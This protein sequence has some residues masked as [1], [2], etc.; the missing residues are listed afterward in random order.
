MGVTVGSFLHPLP[1]GV[2]L[3]RG[4]SRPAPVCPAPRPPIQMSLTGLRGSARGAVWAQ[5]FR[6]SPHPQTGV[7]LGASSQVWAGVTVGGGVGGPEREFSF[8]CWFL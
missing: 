6:A 7:G 1:P 8:P 4:P 2:L 5:G 3:P